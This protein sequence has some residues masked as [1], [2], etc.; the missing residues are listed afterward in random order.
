MC[1]RGKGADA[2]VATLRNYNLRWSCSLATFR[3]KNLAVA[4]LASVLPEN[5][6]DR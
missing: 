3:V 6:V 1:G 4:V 2:V 5:Q